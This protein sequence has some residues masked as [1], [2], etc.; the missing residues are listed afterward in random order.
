MSD[1][2]VSVVMPV[3]NAASTLRKSIDSVL[4]QS[5]AGFELLAVDDGSSDESL[6]ILDD[7]TARDPRVRV[8]RMPS[9]G[10]VAA[11]R[12]HALDAARGNYIAFLDSDDG[13]HPH[14]LARQL[15]AMRAQSAKVSYTA[16]DRIG[17]DGTLLSRVRPPAFVTYADM[18]MSNRIG[19]LTGMYDRT[20]GDARFERVGHEDY[21]FWLDRVKRAGRAICVDPGESLAWYLVRGGSVSSNKFRAARWQWHIYR[22][23]E[24]LGLTASIGY[25]L[26]YAINALRKRA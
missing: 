8:L 15:A 24:R 22:R 1:S 17:E 7:Y 4:A 16:Y 18:L 10:G 2:L 3:Y 19:N 9:N 26:H 20:L 5:H 21:V 12:N 11:A 13:W 25:M 14:K 23:I 6:R